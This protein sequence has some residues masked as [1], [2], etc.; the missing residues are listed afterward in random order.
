MLLRHEGGAEIEISIR[1]YQFPAG[2]NVWDLNWLVVSL[3]LRTDRG[4][5]QAEAPCLLT[6]EARRLAAWFGA[7]LDSPHAGSLQELRFVEPQIQLQLM[8]QTREA[9]SLRLL[10]SHGFRPAWAEEHREF[11][12][13]LRLSHSDMRRAGEALAAEVGAF[14]ERE[15]PQ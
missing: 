10:L 15:T 3:L 8:E 2:D 12:V 14:P 6:W 1:G 7:V 13:D 4:S 11:H 9:T 5:W